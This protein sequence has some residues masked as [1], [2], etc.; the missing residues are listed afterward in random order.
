MS[1]FLIEYVTMLIWRG[2]FLFILIP[3]IKHACLLERN[4]GLT[5]CLH[6]GWWGASVCAELC[7]FLC[8]SN[9]TGSW[10]ELPGPTFEYLV[11]LHIE[12]CIMQYDHLEFEWFCEWWLPLGVY[13]FC[14]STVL[15]LDVKFNWSI[16]MTSEHLPLWERV[17][18][19]TE[20][21][22]SCH[23]AF[24]IPEGSLE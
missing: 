5:S 8:R 4:V 17:V 3:A 13:R 6:F 14:I 15:F 10:N 9:T 18:L 24:L 11:N 23:L 20:N 12:I 22:F 19:C 16:L 21:S 7:A 2:N 1:M